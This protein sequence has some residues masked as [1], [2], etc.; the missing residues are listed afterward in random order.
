M[1]A[2]HRGM[3]CPWIGCLVPVSIEL[4]NGTYTRVKKVCA[5]EPSLNTC[6]VLIRGISS[7]M[8]CSLDY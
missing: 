2:L 3:G 8:K 6:T 4:S 1:T 5:T 7:T